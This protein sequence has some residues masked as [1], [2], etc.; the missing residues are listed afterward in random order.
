MSTSGKEVEIIPPARQ[1][2]L[3]THKR[4]NSPS[5][6]SYHEPLGVRPGGLVSSTLTRWE[7]N[8]HTR[9]Y[10]ALSDRT[11]AETELVNAN[12]ALGTS[13]MKNAHV[14]HELEE[15]PETLA[16]DRSKRQLKRANELSEAYHQV[17]IAE[18][19]RRLERMEAARNIVLARTVLAEERQRYIAA[20]IGLLNAEQRLEAQKKFGP[21]YHELEWQ[22]KIAERELGVEER[23]AVLNEHRKRIGSRPEAVSVNDLYEQRAQM[24][25][26]G[27]DTSAVDAEILQTK[28]ARG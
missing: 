26:D 8:R 6:V 23:L 12:T 3:P 10:S 1:S 13:L 2:N 17:E 14:R 20:R 7:A 22:E 28:R 16:T 24:N 9:V 21:R 4:E 25:A 18:A 11:R 19:R 5:G 27:A 15:L